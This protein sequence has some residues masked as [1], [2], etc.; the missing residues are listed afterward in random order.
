MRAYDYSAQG[1]ITNE[2]KH[3]TT[4][5]LFDRAIEYIEARREDG[6][7]F[8]AFLSIPDP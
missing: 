3:Y 2:E 1:E 7:N 5:Y 8:L 6:K 4:D